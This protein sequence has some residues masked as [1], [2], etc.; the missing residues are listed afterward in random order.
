MS[1]WKSVKQPVFGLSGK[2]CARCARWF[3]WGNFYR[4]SGGYR[5]TCTQVP[6]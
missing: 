5:D 2:Q 4:Q 1:R 6:A 3:A